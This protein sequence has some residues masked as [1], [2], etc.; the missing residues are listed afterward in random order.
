MDSS[1]GND[2]VNNPPNKTSHEGVD[3]DLKYML[4]QLCEEVNF[5]RVSLFKSFSVT[6]LHP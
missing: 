1:A 6:S 4:I 3:D 2:D 5:L